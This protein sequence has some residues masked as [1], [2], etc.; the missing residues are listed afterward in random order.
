M[1]MPLISLIYNNLL[2]MTGERWLFGM[3]IVLVVF[4]GNKLPGYLKQEIEMLLV[5]TFINH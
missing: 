2:F 3:G 5:S 4:P 1:R